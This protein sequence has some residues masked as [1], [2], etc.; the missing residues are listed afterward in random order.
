MKATKGE[1]IFYFINGTILLL[2]SLACLY[3][4]VYV[5]SASL[6][7][8]DAV[9]RGEVILLPKGLNL[10]AYREVLKEKMIWTGYGNSIFIAFF[11]TL[12]TVSFVILGSYPLSKPRFRGRKLFNILVSIPLWFG[13][14]L[15]PAYLNYVDLGLLDT[16]LALII[17]S[18][19]AY[20][21][22]LTRTYFQ[23]IPDSM[24]ESAFLDGANSWQVLTR[25]YIPLSKPCIATIAL[26]SLIGC[27]NSYIWPMILLRQDDLQPLQV[28]LKKII[29]DTTFGANTVAGPQGQSDTIIEYSSDMLVYSTIV[30]SI[31]PM[32]LI[33]PFIQKYFK[34]G[35]ML[36]AVKG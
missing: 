25:I 32:L 34:D 29:I 3:P 23:S 27:W 14:G 21:V 22:L 28:V 12:F 19:P 9:M 33:Y 31:V 7:D 1:K 15:I 10:G 24:E 35:I 2:F 16:R 36:G 4:L 30:V 13:G 20:F 6:S 26:M 8:V 11:G 5:L 17:S 18:V